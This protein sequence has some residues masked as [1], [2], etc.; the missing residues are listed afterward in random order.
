MPAEKTIGLVTT[1]VSRS[2][3]AG[4]EVCFQGVLVVIQEG[5]AN[6]LHDFSLVQV[7]AGSETHLTIQKKLM[8]QADQL[9]IDDRQ[10]TRRV[11]PA[12]VIFSRKVG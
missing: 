7:D 1:C 9:V 11:S 3:V 6:Y 12:I 8:N 4:D 10:D 2:R 5:T